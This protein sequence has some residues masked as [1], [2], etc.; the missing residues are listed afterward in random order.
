[1]HG[2][3]VLPDGILHA[4]FLFPRSFCGFEGHF[5]DKPVLPG[6]CTILAAIV[7][8]EA[9]GGKPLDLKEVVTAKFLATIPPETTV[10]FE[11]RP[12]QIQDA[13][14]RI[15]AV[16]KCSEQRVADL[17]LIVSSVDSARRG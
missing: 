1:M 6:T 12:L 3:T 8:L 9:G 13:M 7:L 17:T 2:V 5:P 16:A 15:R 10:E 14:R 4:S 11:C